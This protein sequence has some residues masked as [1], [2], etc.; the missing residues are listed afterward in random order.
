MQSQQSYQLDG[1]DWVWETRRTNV[2]LDVSPPTGPSAAAYAKRRAA[3][4]A[5][6][7]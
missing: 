3:R 7:M 6:A 4:M 2:R 5:R 1:D